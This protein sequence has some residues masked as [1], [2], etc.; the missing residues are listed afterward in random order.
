MAVGS[1]CPS[2]GLDRWQETTVA[3]VAHHPFWMML[4]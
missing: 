1:W 4:P 2:G 3:P